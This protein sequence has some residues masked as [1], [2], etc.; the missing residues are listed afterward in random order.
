MP[1]AKRLRDQAGSPS[2][3]VHISV[4]H[5][6]FGGSGHPHQNGLLTHP[7]DLD[8]PFKLDIDV[9]CKINSYRHQYADN[10]NISLLPAIVSTSTRLHSE[11]WVFFFY[12]PTWT[13]TR[14]CHNFTA[15]RM[16]LQHNSDRFSPHGILSRPEEHSRARLVKI[17]GVAD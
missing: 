9:Q 7:R 2:L 10:Q 16:P 13:P 11:F 1:H 17:G 15:T 8:T 12:R 5:E 4:T 6:R 14:T 3:V